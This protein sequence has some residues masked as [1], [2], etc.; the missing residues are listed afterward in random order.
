[1]QMEMLR[2]LSDGKPRNFGITYCSDAR[3]MVL[4]SS[5]ARFMVFV[6]ILLFFY[7]QVETAK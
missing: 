2:A 5:I 1:M 6:T 4:N 7:Q 3:Y